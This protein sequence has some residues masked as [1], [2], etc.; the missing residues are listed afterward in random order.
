[1]Y[2]LH[3]FLPAPT[4]PALNRPSQVSQPLRKAKGLTVGC[5]YLHSVITSAEEPQAWGAPHSDSS[6]LFPPLGNTLRNTLPPFENTGFIKANATVSSEI[7]WK[8]TLP[9]LSW[10]QL[11]VKP[12]LKPP[13]SCEQPSLQTLCK[14]GKQTLVKWSLMWICCDWAVAKGGNA[15]W[16]WRPS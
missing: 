10:Q 9:L 5:Q 4:Q 8:L 6:F 3:N 12:A 2:P 16:T 7:L 15:W 1:M 11:A 13:T 14:Q